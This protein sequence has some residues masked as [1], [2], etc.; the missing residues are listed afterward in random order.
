M[1][2]FLPLIILAFVIGIGYLRVACLIGKLTRP[3]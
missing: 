1:V 3:D 2:P